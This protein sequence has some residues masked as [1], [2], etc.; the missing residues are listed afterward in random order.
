MLAGLGGLAAGAMLAGARAAHAGPLDPPAGPVTS[1]GKTLTEIEPRTPINSTN[2]PGDANSIYKITAPGS[3]YLAGNLMGVSGRHGIEIDS[4]DVSIDLCGFNV[5]GV[6]G[7]LDG[8]N[9]TSRRDRLS[10]CNGIVHRWGG[11]GIHIAP[12]GQG[13]GSRVERIISRGNTLHGIVVGVSSVVRDCEAISNGGQGFSGAFASLFSG[14]IAYGNV[15]GGFTLSQGSTATGC[16]AMSNNGHGFLT[17]L[18]ALMAHCAAGNNGGPG[19]SMSS[20]GTIVECESTFNTGDGILLGDSSSVRGCRSSSNGT[21]SMGAGI[22]AT[23]RDNH[24]EGNN[25]TGNVRG[26]DIDSGGNFIARNTCSGNTT[27][28]WDIASGN[29]ILIVAAAT[30]G[31]AVFGNSG[32]TPPGSTDPNANF[33]Y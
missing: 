19:F 16:S 33:T 30:T 29:T 5:E 28:N 4:D 2:T 31:G 3:Y 32:G 14:S 23:G 1:T 20:G 7:S 8:I 18:T 25:C 24:I 26:F 6:P 21:G 27:V 12:I 15:Q 9:V 11:S 22:H 17:T 10:I 13:D